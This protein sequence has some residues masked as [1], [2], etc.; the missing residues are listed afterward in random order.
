MSRVVAR[1]HTEHSERPQHKG[2]VGTVANST[3]QNDQSN[4]NDGGCQCK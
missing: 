2:L 1:Q 4:Q 3:K